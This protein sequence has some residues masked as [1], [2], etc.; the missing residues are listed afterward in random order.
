MDGGKKGAIALLRCPARVYRSTYLAKLRVLSGCNC[1]GLMTHS[2]LEPNLITATWSGFAIAQTPQA[3]SNLAVKHFPETQ[4]G[5]NRE[6]RTV[7][8]I[9]MQTTTQSSNPR[10]FYLRR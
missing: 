3:S 10:C 4:N 7:T 5:D 8:E 1:Q 9:T 6:P 2:K